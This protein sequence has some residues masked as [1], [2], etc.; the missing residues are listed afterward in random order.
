MPNKNKGF[1]LLE[2]IVAITILMISIVGPLSLASKGIVYADYVKDEITAYNLAQ[3]AMEAIRNI[4]DENVNNYSV[5]E[6]LKD[7]DKCITNTCRLDIWNQSGIRS[8]LEVYSVGGVMPSDWQLMKIVDAGV[9][10]GKVVLYGYAFNPSLNLNY[11]SDAV[12]KSIFTRKIT[13]KRAD[14]SMAITDP[15]RRGTLGLATPDEVNVTIEVSWRRIPFLP[16]S[17]KISEN[18]F[19]I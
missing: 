1:T 11:S 16:R 8:G 2:T 6:W 14:Y 19:S 9:G 18:L 10:Q 4:R 17:I 5:S 15:I 7:I 3:E 12:R 13:V